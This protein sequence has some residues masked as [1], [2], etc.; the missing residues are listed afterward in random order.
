M[1]CRRRRAD[2]KDTRSYRLHTQPGSGGAIRI[3]GDVVQPADVVLVR[4]RTAVCGIHGRLDV[5]MQLGEVW[6]I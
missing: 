6:V 3:L 2:E 1:G 5:D 4:D